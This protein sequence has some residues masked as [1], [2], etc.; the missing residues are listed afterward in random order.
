MEE[1]LDAPVD[2][3]SVKMLLA[4]IDCGVPKRQSP[5]D[6]AGFNVFKLC[7]VNHYETIHSRI[8][9]E[10]LN[11]TGSHGC[12]KAFLELF[13]NQKNVKHYLERNQFPL[14]QGD[15]GT[16]RV[17]TEESLDGGRCDITLHWCGY[18]IVI[19]N[20]IYASDQNA[21][22]RRYKESIQRQNEKPLL[23]YLTLDGHDASKG[24]I[25][26]LTETEYC[27]LS[28][29]KDITQWIEASAKTAYRSPFVR[30][31]LCQ[32]L[33]LI[34]DL[35]K[36]QKEIK[37]NEPVIRAIKSSIGAFRA[38][39]AIA[40]SLQNARGEI[41]KMVVDS[42]KH[43]IDKEERFNG[44]KLDSTIS[45][46]VKDTGQKHVYWH[47]FEIRKEGLPY[48]I[49]C[50]FQ[51]KGALRELFIGLKKSEFAKDEDVKCFLDTAKKRIANNK[52]DFRSY[53][54]VDNIGWLYGSWP[55]GAFSEL[56]NWSDDV[57][58]TL[59]DEAQ[60][61]QFAKK[62]ADYMY[63]MLVEAAEVAE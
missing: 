34:K 43:I 49:R 7:S 62:I 11:P 3:D 57:L 30:E 54:Q 48:V 15:L 21:Q 39:C 44:W 58:A 16:V 17:H 37:M 52:Y 63:N 18:C 61:F 46:F 22:L 14:G 60:R 6:D 13:L 47:G 32:Y 59:I 19:E 55:R 20:K 51:E 29:A 53:S 2:L 33:N 27:C 1:K 50:E 38:S 10:F 45:N 42:I 24:S 31:T 40:A 26:N 4:T 5:N 12:G 9:A 56:R 28:Y 35:S 23:F 36:M 8:I 25:G 41:A